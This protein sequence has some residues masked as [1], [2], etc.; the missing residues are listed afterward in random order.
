MIASPFPGNRRDDLHALGAIWTGRG[1]LGAQ[2]NKTREGNSPDPRTAGQS[3][4]YAAGLFLFLC[5]LFPSRI[6][7]LSRGCA[8]E[9]GSV[10]M[11]VYALRY[12]S[13]E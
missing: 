12:A 13:R 2:K 9:T 11:S 6:L 1:G 10:R 7:L 5:S 3:I 4:F 8:I